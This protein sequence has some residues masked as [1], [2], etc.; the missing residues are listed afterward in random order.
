MLYLWS[1][2]QDLLN[3]GGST[4]LCGEEAS[5][6]SARYSNVQLDSILALKIY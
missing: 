6:E 4:G 2:I 1:N 3:I 5:C